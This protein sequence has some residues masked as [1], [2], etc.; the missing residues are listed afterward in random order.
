VL[1]TSQ[2]CLVLHGLEA[3]GALVQQGI[4]LCILSSKDLGPIWSS[5]T[6]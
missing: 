4:I 6:F 1:H 2:V 5:S 3:S